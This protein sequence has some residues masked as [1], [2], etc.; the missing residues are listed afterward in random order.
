M[1]SFYFLTALAMLCAASAQ[2]Q[3]LQY[4][5]ARP[6][7]A[8]DPSVAR[9]AYL[10]DKVAN[11]ETSLQGCQKND[12]CCDPVCG[13]SRACCHSA[14]IIGGYDFLLLRPR[15]SNSIAYGRAYE[16]GP[17]E[18]L[19]ATTFQT[20]YEMAPRFWLGY[21]GET[22]LGGR[23]RYMQFDHMLMQGELL[24]D[25]DNSYAVPYFNNIWGYEAVQVEDGGLLTFF[26]D[27]EMHVLDLD[28]M[29][30]LRWG[31]TELTI[32]GGLRYAKLD[33]L[34]VASGTGIES[35]ATIFN[36]TFEGVGPTVFLEMQRQ[37]GQSS[38]SLVGGAR[39][40]VLFGRTRHWSYWGS[41]IGE[42]DVALERGDRTT[43]V[44]EGMI[45]VQYDRALT[46]GV[47]T[48]IRAG[49]EGQLW[50][51]VGSPT[52]TLGDM[53]MQGLSL[54]IGITR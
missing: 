11:L 31:R 50:F 28:V 34:S 48:F 5:A 12:S 1:R 18:V 6:G 7:V 51:D 49:W 38:V 47:D 32:G 44:I 14:G 15:F 3:T 46:R 23:I 9:I 19:S 52:S 40:S 53:G 54:S 20:D 4:P 16:D 24:A 33:F 36:N 17:V 25:A 37:I 42:Y 22:G 45:G 30:D 29:Q 21:M 27:M 13:V 43:G 41:T 26:H 35:V 8:T 10:E 2:A 39:G